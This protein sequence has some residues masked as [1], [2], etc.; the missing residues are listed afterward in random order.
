LTNCDSGTQIHTRKFTELK[1]IA[2]ADAQTVGGVI[3]NIAAAI[4][5]L[6]I[7]TLKFIISLEIKLLRD[8]L[9]KRQAEVI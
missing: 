4:V 3:R 8:F 5:E 6:F 7:D 1:K 2:G 9:L